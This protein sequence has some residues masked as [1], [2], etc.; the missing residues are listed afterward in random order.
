MSYR[1]RSGCLESTTVDIHLMSLL[2]P[3]IKTQ[4]CNTDNLSSAQSQ[5]LRLED[6]IPLIII[7]GKTRAE[8]SSNW[9]GVPAALYFSIVYSE[10]VVGMQFVV[11]NRSNDKEPDSI[12][13]SRTGGQWFRMLHNCITRSSGFSGVLHGFGTWI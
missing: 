7:Q 3:F 11:A 8:P 10:I 6:V 1:L 12:R 2:S 13:H 5:L 4:E 9:K